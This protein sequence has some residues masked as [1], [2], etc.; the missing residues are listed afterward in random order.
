MI[1]EMIV[2]CVG[3]FIAIIWVIVAYFTVVKEKKWLVYVFLLLSIF[4]PAE[5]IWNIIRVS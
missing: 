1:N 3:S 2:L 5:I 4:S